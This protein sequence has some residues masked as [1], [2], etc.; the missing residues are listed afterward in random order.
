MA[1]SFQFSR[2]VDDFD[3]TG[4]EYRARV[5]GADRRQRRHSGCDTAGDAA[6]RQV[7]RRVRRRGIKSS[8]PSVSS[9][10]TR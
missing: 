4:G 1:V 10:S 3:T 7:R 9:A 2:T 8:G 6:K 5:A